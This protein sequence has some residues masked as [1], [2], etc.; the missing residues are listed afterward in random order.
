LARAVR[1]PVLAAEIVNAGETGVP[2]AQR[3]A[4]AAV[5]LGVARERISIED[6]STNTGENF[7]SSWELLTARA[8]HPQSF[9]IVQKPYMERRAPM[10]H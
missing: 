9:I 4:D 6:R 7:A 5:G 3:F 10:R 1:G 2:E 8:H